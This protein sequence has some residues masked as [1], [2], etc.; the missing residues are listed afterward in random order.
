[1]SVV[2]A[3]AL[4]ACAVP[5]EAPPAATNST[6][7]QLDA[8]ARQDVAAGVPGVVIRVDDGTGKPIEVAK[9][10]DWTTADH[11]LTADDQFRMGSNTK[12]MTAVLVLQ[13]VAEHKLSLEDSVE[14]WLPGLVPNGKNITL[15]ML[16]NHTS[17]LYD[18]LND[19]ETLAAVTGQ[20]E[21]TKTP[22]ELLAVAAK[23][24]PLFA[25]GA[26]YSYSNTGYLALGMVLEAVTG[27][28]PE[29]LLRQRII[30]PLGLRDT[31]LAT[32]DVSRDGARLADSYEP[33]AEHLAPLLPD[34][35]PA[36]TAFAGPA[37]AGHVLTTSINP[38]WA[39][40]A[41]AVVSTPEDWQRFLRAL[42]AGSLLPRAQLAEMR[43]TVIESPGTAN[44]PRYGLGLEEYVS[45][46]GS[47][48][49]HTGRIPGYASENYTNAEGT[50]SVTVVTTTMFGLFDPKLAA[51]DQKVVDGAVCAM[52]GKP[53]PK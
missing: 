48:W 20:D 46:C 35:V 2:A 36:G 17:G 1:M 37:R 32:N 7:R 3:L 16:L 47:V 10:A 34:G 12:T 45:P 29:T 51:A 5:E 30:N 39:G 13:L 38:Y 22:A 33:D 52:L 27:R 25:P 42:A 24:P 4:A 43:K 40:A 9:Q 8:L 23:Y 49:G 31:Y 26:Q 53:L 19:P 6:A 28:S 50:R 15:R 11:R 44:S 18:Y 14:K 21:R 41:G